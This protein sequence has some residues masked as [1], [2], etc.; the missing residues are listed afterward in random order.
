MLNRIELIGRVGQEIKIK[1]FSGGKLAS[2]SLATS[3]KYTKNGEKV[4]TTQWHNIVI[5]NEHLVKLAEQYLQKG[6]QIYI[7]GQMTYRKYEGTSGT[8]NVAEVV[9][10]KYKGELQMLDSRSDSPAAPKHFVVEQTKN[11]F[12]DDSIPF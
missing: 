10:Q 7:A 4:E 8:V 12:M 11:D 6:S 3:E 2:F 5:F 9:L 1:E